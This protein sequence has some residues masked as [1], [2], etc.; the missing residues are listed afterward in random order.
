VTSRAGAAGNFLAP[1]SQLSANAFKTVV[2]IDLIGSYNTLKATLPHLLKSAAANKSDGRQRTSFFSLPLHHHPPLDSEY[3]YIFKILIYPTASSNGTGGRIIFISAT[4][5]YTGT[6]LQSHVS[7]AKAGI[8]ALSASTAIEF[9]PLGLTSNIIAPGPIS[10]TEGMERLA[11]A[12]A[13]A[14]MAKGIPLQRWGRVREIADATVYLFAETGGFV[15][16][17]NVVVDGGQWRMAGRGPQVVEYVLM[18]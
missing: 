9:G 11:K 5:H 14:E 17:T 7:A 6:P 13:E 1:I 10:G 8:D 12:G 15:T 2:D 16:G 3:L 18:I 4:L